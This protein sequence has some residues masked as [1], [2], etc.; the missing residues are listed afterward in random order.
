MLKN[1]LKTALIAVMVLG[2]SNAVL[3]ESKELEDKELTMGARGAA[4]FGQ[5]ND[6]AEGQKDSFR[7]HGQFNIFANA[8]KGNMML[9]GNV[10]SYP[11]YSQ[12]GSPAT[13]LTQ[14]ANVTG[15]F[16][17]S[18]ITPIGLLSMGRLEN[19][20]ASKPVTSGGGT[21]TADG[22][23]GNIVAPT[24]AG[25]G[26]APG[27][28]LLLPIGDF[29][30]E[31]TM[32]TSGVSTFRTGCGTGMNICQDSEGSATALGV[33][34]KFGPITARV[35]TISEVI[36][37]YDDDVDQLAASYMHAGASME[38]GS[39]TVGLS[40]VQNSIEMA[41][42]EALSTG[43]AVLCSATTKSCDTDKITHTMTV[44]GFLFT[45]KDLGPG[46]LNFGYETNDWNDSHFD[47]AEEVGGPVGDGLGSYFSINITRWHLI[48]DVEVVEGAGYQLIYNTGTKAKKYPGIDAETGQFF[49]GALYAKF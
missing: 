41:I 14:E 32:Y 43:I 21:L 40:I 4:I 26:S 47:A 30:I 34:A 1:I 19:N 17:V 45:M 28:D 25:S 35:G 11:G 37:E 48:Y 46:K 39:M 12:T 20:I 15:S 44:M 33:N 49:G 9:S 13:K 29:A 2:S 23:L 36:G 42:P 31:A 3:A 6:G 24:F 5:G 27:L 8:N 7:G 18:M 22:D 38:I 16:K 10:Q